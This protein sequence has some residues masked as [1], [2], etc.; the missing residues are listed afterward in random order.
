MMPTGRRDLLRALMGLALSAVAYK[1]RNGDCGLW[2][3]L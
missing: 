2:Y 1:E 3:F